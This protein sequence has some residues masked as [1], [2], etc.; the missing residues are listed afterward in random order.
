G[1]R[2]VAPPSPRQ[3][4]HPLLTGVRVRSGPGPLPLRQFYPPTLRGHLMQLASSL[5]NLPEAP[6]RLVDV[7]P[8]PQSSRH[9][10]A[11]H[12]MPRLMEVLCR[13]LGGRGVAAADMAARLALPQFDPA[14]SFFQA[15][16]TGARR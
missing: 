7:A 5:R 14:R 16:L 15:F 12:G 6:L 11:H 10:G 3:N 9:D 2:P 1:S 13:V 4:R 8:R